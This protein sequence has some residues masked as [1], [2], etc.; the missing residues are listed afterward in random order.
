MKKI[1]Y[2]IA[3]LFV[4]ISIGVVWRLYKKEV[5]VPVPVT[6]FEECVAGGNPVMESYPRQCRSGNQTFTEIIGNENELNNL[7]HLNNPR[8]NQVISS[9]LVIQG[10][11]RGGWF[12]EASF[13][14]ILTDWDG[15]IIASGVATAQGDWMTNDFVPFTAT[16]TFKNPTY[17]NNGSL[18]L[19]KDNPS[20][21]P[22]NDKALE[23]PV[24]FKNIDNPATVPAVKNPPTSIAPYDSG[25]QGKVTL[26]PVCPVMRNP[27]EPECADK[28]YETTVQIIVVGSTK[29][30]PFATVKTD[31]NGAYKIMLPPGE[32]AVQ[33]GGG[34]PFP[35]CSTENITVTPK[36]VR[37]VNISC[38]S[39]IR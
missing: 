20:G 35:R 3:V 15:L 24:I 23:I 26:G 32:Y 4:L 37:V 22:E 5:P 19:K 12:F 6:T 14:V 28:A 27:P 2:S 36:V 25:V 16:L 30:S 21:L 31:K 11:A 33:P 17:K 9:P 10:E 7:I 38:D 8:P 18:I 1:L 29:S 34:N 13:P 39:G